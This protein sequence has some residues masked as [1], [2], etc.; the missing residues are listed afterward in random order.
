MPHTIALI[1]AGGTGSRF[2]SIRPKQFT[3]VGGCTVLEHSVTAFEHCASIDEIGIISHPNHLEEVETIFSQNSHPKI[4]H[5]V[6]GGLER[7]DSTIRGLQ[8]FFGPSIVTECEDSDIPT[9]DVHLLVHD[10]VRPGVS[11]S[12]I[13]RVCSAL[14]KHAAVNVVLPVVDTIVEI[15]ANG[16]MQSIADRTRLRRVQTPQGFHASVL[17]EAYRRAVA[18]ASFSTTDE[19]GVVFRYCPEIEIDMVEGEERNLKLTYPE[20]LTFL[21][22]CLTTHLHQ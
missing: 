7:R 2:G 5:I 4:T 19:C 9:G 13:S 8:A 3:I 22:H 15:N 21:F 11:P 12:L 16:R 6:A 1:L 20:D 14:D 10:A 18:D 17:I